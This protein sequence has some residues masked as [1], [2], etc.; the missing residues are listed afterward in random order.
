MEEQVTHLVEKTWG[1]ALISS[2]LCV[3]LR[4]HL[5]NPISSSENKKL[6][7]FTVAKFQTIPSNERLLIAIS[8]IPGSGTPSFPFKLQIS[9]TPHFH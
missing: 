4:K 7:L 1:K 6:M 8:G 2:H 9:S 5:I 3:M